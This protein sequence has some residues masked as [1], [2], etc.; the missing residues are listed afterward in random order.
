MSDNDDANNNSN[1]KNNNND[2]DT[3]GDDGDNN[4]DD[5]Y[6]EEDPLMKKVSPCKED[7]EIGEINTLQS[8]TFLATFGNL[9]V[10]NETY[11]P[12]GSS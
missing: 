1:N 7:L 10:H 8:T 3:N 5:N 11:L 9:L 6:Y 12:K 4:N 2:S